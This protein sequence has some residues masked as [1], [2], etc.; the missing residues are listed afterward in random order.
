M[1]DKPA[2]EET[3]LSQ[4]MSALA[5]G[6]R[7]VQGL[8]LEDEYDYQMSYPEFRQLIESNHE[9]L[10]DVLLLAVSSSAGLSDH[11]QDYLGL[12]IDTLDDPLLW[13]ACADI[14]DGLLEQAENDSSSSSMAQDILNARNQA[15][16]S[17][18]RLLHGIVDMDKP[19]DVFKFST[20]LIG[21][22]EPFIPPI[23]KKHHAVKPLDLTL[24]P[25][26]GLEDRFGDLRSRPVLLDKTMIAPSSHVP[27]CYQAELEALKYTQSQLE[28]PQSKPSRIQKP[29]GPLEATWIDTARALKDLAK[30]IESE[31]VREIAL[32][33]EAHS[34]RSFDGMICL[35]QITFNK[36]NYLIDPFPIWKH[37]SEALGPIL[38]NP[39]I[40][41]VLHGADSDVQWLQRDFGI[42]IVNL[43]DTGRAARALHMQSAGYAHLLHHYVG[44][45][46]DKSHQLSDWRQR[47]LPKAM[48][49]YA[50]MDTHFLLDIY[51]QLKYDL[52]QH[53]TASIEQV[54]GESMKVCM[55]RYAP[56]PFK[57]NGY[58]SI[59]G[60]G[61]RRRGTGRSTSKTELNDTQEQV[62]KALWDWRDQIARQ[63]DESHAY[64][65][66]NAALLRLALS[67]PS[68]L[69]ALQGLLQPIP[70][71]LLRNAK[72]VLDLIQSCQSQPTKSQSLSSAFFKPATADDD[73]SSLTNRVLRSPVLGTEALYRQAGWISPSL[74]GPSKN[75]MEVED[76]VT[77][78]TDDDNVNDGSD[79]Q[80]IKP[81]RLL[82]VHE[83]NQSFQ[84]RQFT[85]H[86]LKLGTSSSN[87]N[88]NDGRGGVD[89]LG[90]ARAA[91][92]Q[93]FEEEAH[94]A[95]INADAIRRTQENHVKMIGL[96][97][98]TSDI[99]EHAVERIN[100]E[101]TTEKPEE[102]EPAIPRSMKEIYQ[103]S[104]RNRRAKKT[105]SLREVQNKKETS[106]LEKAEA[107]LKERGMEGYFDNLPGTPKRQRTKSTGNSS[108]S[109]VSED[110]PNDA[111]NASRDDDIAF[112]KDI[113]WIKDK[114]GGSSTIVDTKNDPQEGNSSTVDEP[115]KD[116]APKP[117]DYSKIGQIGAFSATPGANP[118]FQGVAVA[119]GHLNQQFGKTPSRNKK[120]SNG[121]AR[122]KQSSRRQTERPERGE[123]RAQVY[124]KR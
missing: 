104:N 72:E 45:V 44:I 5:A 76:I 50:I 2:E 74:C 63:A 23:T 51:H 36:E 65:C 107:L 95:Q 105:P 59:M 124:K 92:A 61:R 48:K 9:S 28:A 98:P 32:D 12:E 56:E 69:T 121:N 38:A 24:H 15:Q 89:G 7:A 84:S 20:N 78:A 43:F 90:S 96:V 88:H 119:G 27:H 80:Q 16:T 112:M 106:E 75:E 29:K 58:K 22:N 26:H 94:L 83:S 102:D 117:Y 71:L 108:S 25:G 30:K 120:Q 60:R 99:E 10:I 66:T 35:I 122:G 81:R 37:I 64:V 93:N 41:K 40:V 62:L 103:I 87:Q 73:D 82:A 33:L 54:L 115:M 21:R 17:F 8:P 18:G 4:L 101:D 79:Q 39:K 34:Y 116:A 77:S 6:A 113:G 67:R 85:A 114:P 19:Q 14:C 55:I 13:E 86:S 123:A 57:P 70:P 1:P 118:F 97:S 49:E 42:Y 91:N 68:T 11:F 3:L 100:R 47:P 109:S 110:A 31:G 52:S 53:A 111:Q 46:A